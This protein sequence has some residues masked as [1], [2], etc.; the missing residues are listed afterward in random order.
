MPLPGNEKFA[1]HCREGAFFCT[2]I[3]NF[4]IIWRK[5][6]FLYNLFMIRNIYI[7]SVVLLFILI[8]VLNFYAYEYFWYWKFW[9]FDIIMHTLGGVCVGLTALWLFFLRSG[10]KQREV[11]KKAVF[12]IAF[13]AISLVGAGWELFEVS[14]KRFIF[15]P[16][17]DPWN[18]ASDL[19]FDGAGCLI[20]VFIFL[21]LYN[22][23]KQQPHT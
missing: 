17:H 6:W 7:S 13:A 11:E 19:F 16:R 8:S 3:V 22:M 5:R 15:L 2:D 10:G 14:T 12:A 1:L 18:T 4:S 9:W 23:I 20:A 21:I